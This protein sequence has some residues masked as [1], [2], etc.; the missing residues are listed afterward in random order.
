MRSRRT[1]CQFHQGLTHFR[2]DNKAIS[3]MIR[4]TTIL[5]RIT[6]NCNAFNGSAH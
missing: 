2:F 4:H 5:P 3:S 1:A 6:H